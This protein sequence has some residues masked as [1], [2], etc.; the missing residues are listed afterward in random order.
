L[1]QPAAAKAFWYH[2]AAHATTSGPWIAVLR[3]LLLLTVCSSA[4]AV[5]LCCCPSTEE[6]VYL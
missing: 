4:A 3:I 5:L 6:P 2:T 1:R